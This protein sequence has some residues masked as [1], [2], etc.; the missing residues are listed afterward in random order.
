MKDPLDKQL[1]SNW[2]AIWLFILV[3]MYSEHYSSKNNMAKYINKFETVFAQ[4]EWLP[5]N[6]R[7][8]EAYWAVL[9]LPNLVS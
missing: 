2:T 5:E 4:L 6:T 8:P 1:A 9:P 7:V 3:V